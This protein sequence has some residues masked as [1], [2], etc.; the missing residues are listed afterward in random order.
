MP[1]LAF[2]FHQVTDLRLFL[3]ARGAD[4]QAFLYEHEPYPVG[5]QETHA[6]CMAERQNGVSWGNALWWA[7]RVRGSFPAASAG[8]SCKKKKEK[9]QNCNLRLICVRWTEMGKWYHKL[10]EWATK[11]SP[12]IPIQTFTFKLVWLMNS[13]RA[14]LLHPQHG[15]NCFP[16]QH[17]VTSEGIRRWKVNGIESETEPRWSLRGRVDHSRSLNYCS[18]HLSVHELLVDLWR[19]SNNVNHISSIWG[20]SKEEKCNL[21]TLFFP[22]TLFT[23]WRARCMSML[24]SYIYRKAQKKM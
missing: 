13:R 24:F 22:S 4:Q 11:T 10:I 1:S 2:P 20:A 23:W 7:K 12:S 15:L 5:S 9:E 18:S 17:Y 3:A 14:L 16:Q 19:M 8:S 6:G 21:S